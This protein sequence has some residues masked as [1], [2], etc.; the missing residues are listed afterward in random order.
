M[1]TGSAGGDRLVTPVILTFN[2]EANIERTLN[3][4]AWAPDVVIVDS[5]SSDATGRLAGRYPNVRWFVRPFDT[6]GQQWEFAIRS[7]GV[8]APYVLALDADYEVPGDFV[9]ELTTDFAA[10]DCAGGVAGFEYRIH[11]RALA[12]SVYPAKLVVFKRDRVRVSQP[13]HSQELSVDGSIYRFRTRLV[14]DDRKSIDRFVR[15]QVEYSRLE[16]GRLQLAGAGRWQDRVRR[17]ALMPLVAG[18]GAYLRSGGPFRGGASLRYA[19]E[20]TVFECLLAL[21]LLDSDMNG[22]PRTPA[23]EDEN[24]RNKG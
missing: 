9:R 13:G 19:Y 15:S 1:T 5:G 21:R 3:A 14:H 16:M 17:L 22:D 24:G 4:L 6:H 10:A 11:G 2:E 18:I 8:T 7:T 23:P 20:R 12:G